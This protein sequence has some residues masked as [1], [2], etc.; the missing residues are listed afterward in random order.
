VGLTL[1]HAHVH[2]F[3]DLLLPYPH[4]EIINF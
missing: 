4:P 3:Q 1:P 2:P